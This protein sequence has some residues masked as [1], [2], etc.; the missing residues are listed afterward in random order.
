MI[1]ERRQRYANPHIIRPLIQTL[2][3]V[4]ILPETPTGFVVEWPDLSQ[5]DEETRSTIESNRASVV[6][7]VPGIAGETAIQY[8]KNGAESLP[9]A[10]SSQVANVDE[11]DPDAVESF[12][13]QFEANQDD[14]PALDDPVELPEKII[15]AGEAAQEA[16]EKGWIPD[17]CGTGR[18]KQRSRQG[19]NDNLTVADLLT[20]DN[21]TP[22]PAYLV[23][24][25]EDLTA[26]G[27][28]T[29]WGEEE[30]SDC[31][32][33]GI[34]RWLYYV[35]WFTEKANELARKRGEEEPY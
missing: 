27:P 11:S 10:E 9:E 3:D 19:A 6:Q 7:A 15:N 22:I 13:E 8:V 29:E 17:N 33:A 21:G 12:L 18:G 23:S 26:E 14:G 35:D 34:G 24:H 16:E 28:P 25:E 32:N 2:Q 5:L 1:A 30:W 20:R 4:G 31:G